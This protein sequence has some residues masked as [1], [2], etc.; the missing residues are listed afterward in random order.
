MSALEAGKVDFAVSDASSLILF[1]KNS[2]ATNLRMITLVYQKN[3][4]AVI[5]NNATISKPSDL[6]GKSG[7]MA[8]PKSSSLSA[9]WS[10][11]VKANN[12]N[13]SSMHITYTTG[14]TE[15]ADLLLE[16]KVQFVVA[17]IDKLPTYNQEAVGTGLKFGAFVMV[18]YGVQLTGYAL[19]TTQAIIQQQPNLVQEMVNATDESLIKSI[20]NPAAAAAALVDYNPQLNATTSQ[21]TFGLIAECCTVNVSGL[22]N[23]LQYG[24]FNPAAVQQT[25]TNVAVAENITSTLNATNYYTDAFSQQP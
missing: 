5:Y 16:G 17:S 14:S 24:W 20:E 22:T 6:N 10:L 21:I 3:F 2:N 18:N 8:S 19:V 23:P 7:A 9:L 12:L 15:T 25:V 4:V 13:A 1:A 11:F